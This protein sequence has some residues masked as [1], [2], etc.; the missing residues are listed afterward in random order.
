MNHNPYSFIYYSNHT[1][2]GHFPTCIYCGC[3]SAKTRAVTYEKSQDSS[4]LY[5]TTDALSIQTYKNKQKVPHKPSTSQKN[6]NLK[7]VQ[8]NKQKKSIRDLTDNH[9]Q[10]LFCTKL[11]MGLIKTNLRTN[12]IFRLANC[13]LRFAVSL[14]ENVF[15]GCFHEKSE[16]RDNHKAPGLLRLL[17]FCSRLYSSPITYL[18]WSSILSATFNCLHNLC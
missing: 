14:S 3:Y 10:L 5:T 18:L 1:L 4:H 16:N 12:K 15:Q 7:H 17:P 13:I 6:P 2:E 11:W 9:S 8:E